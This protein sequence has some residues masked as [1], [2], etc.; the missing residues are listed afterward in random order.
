VK[1]QNF[2]DIV[3]PDPDPVFPIFINGWRSRIKPTHWSLGRGGCG[4]TPYLVIITFKQAS[5]DAS[6]RQVVN[7]NDLYRTHVG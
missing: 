5:A 6:A 1:Q 3:I 2:V 4:M 7:Y